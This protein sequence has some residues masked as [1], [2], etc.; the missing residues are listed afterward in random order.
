MKRTLVAMM[1]VLLGLTMAS[2]GKA[3]GK[4]KT[5]ILWEY[6]GQVTNSGP[7]STQ[8]GNLTNVVGAAQGSYYTFYTTATNTA[9]TTNG[10]LKIVDRKG[11]TTIYVTNAPGDFANPDSFRAGA[12]V[13]VS[14]LQQ[15][16]IVNSTT[17]L[18]TVVNVNTVTSA[19]ED[20][21]VE[22]G[23][24]IRTSLTGQL[25]SGTPPPTGWFGGVAMRESGR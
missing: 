4:G 20:E 21:I 6:V 10:P 23:Q 14:D 24:V 19:A 7:N 2:A 17:G 3:D 11:T 1:A 25:N 8:Y 5:A 22:T 16:V 13:V 12:P 15:Q 18:F 9:V